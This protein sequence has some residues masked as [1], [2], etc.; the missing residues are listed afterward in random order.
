MESHSLWGQE[1][2]SKLFITLMDGCASIMQ[3]LARVFLTE[4]YEAMDLVQRR[5]Q[6]RACK[7][8]KGQSRKAFQLLETSLRQ[9]WK[10]VPPP[11][12]LPGAI[13]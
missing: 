5:M 10:G 2:S 9:S 13:W 6:A 7:C 4:G 1:L 11:Q 8:L 3:E 12:P